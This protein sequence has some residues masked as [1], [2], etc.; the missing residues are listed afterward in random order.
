MGSVSLG[1]VH[2]VSL[3]RLHTFL[4]FGLVSA[5][6]WSRLRALV[7]SRVFQDALGCYWVS[8]LAVFAAA[9]LTW[10]FWSERCASGAAGG[11]CGSHEVFAIFAF[12]WS[13][14]GLAGVA[15]V[16]LLA[17]ET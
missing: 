1:W 17:S 8:E 4:A 14:T 2:R 5:A 9:L 16:D 6:S 15:A 13:F 11:G 12:A 3:V 10:F 7:H